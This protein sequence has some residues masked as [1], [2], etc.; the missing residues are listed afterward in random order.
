MLHSKVAVAD[1]CLVQATTCHAIL[2]QLMKIADTPDFCWACRPADGAL[3]VT[4]I[5]QIASP[6]PTL[7]AWP[8]QGTVQCTVRSLLRVGVFALTQAALAAMAFTQTFL[9]CHP[10]RFALVVVEP[11]IGFVVLK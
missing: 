5:S 1:C 9:N 11:S 2:L 10:T 6:R 8:M 4:I 7:T 3:S